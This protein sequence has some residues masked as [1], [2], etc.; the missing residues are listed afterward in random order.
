MMKQ[1]VP[2]VTE[3]DVKRI[4]LRD[5]GVERVSRALAILDEYGK[6]EWNRPGSPRV[7]LAILKLAN[8]DLDLLAT[9]SATAIED[10]R[11]VIA[12]AE[13]PRWSKEIGFNG[14]D[15]KTER[16]VIENEWTQYCEWL[17]QNDRGQG[18]TFN[19]S[20]VGRVVL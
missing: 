1:P 3:D 6:Q 19:I 20:L 11:D 8:G 12:W 5:F 16:Q 13:Y 14:S 4:V 2:T 10:F 9:H 17:K 15:R 18:A 7:R